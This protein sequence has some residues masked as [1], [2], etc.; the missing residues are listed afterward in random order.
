MHKHSLSQLYF[1]H[2]FEGTV[3]HPKLISLDFKKWRL[4]TPFGT[5]SNARTRPLMSRGLKHTHIFFTAGTLGRKVWNF[6]YLDKIF[7]TDDMKANLKFFSPFKPGWLQTTWRL[8]HFFLIG[9]G[10]K[11]VTHMSM[12]SVSKLI[13]HWDNIGFNCLTWTL[14]YT[15]K[16]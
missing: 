1:I 14:Q 6:L 7:C 2:I 12:A 8:L 5:E 13:G 16:K 3:S 15:L 4:P 10:E 11:I 9:L